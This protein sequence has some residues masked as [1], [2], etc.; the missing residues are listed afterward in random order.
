MGSGPADAEVAPLLR[1]HLARE[2]AA[3]G[4]QAK[5]RFLENARMLADNGESSDIDE[6]ITLFGKKT[7]SETVGGHRCDVYQIGQKTACV[8][9]GAPL[10]MLR[11]TDPRQGLTMVAKKVTLNATVPPAATILPKG[12]KWKQGEADDADFISN[13][14]ELKKQS[15]PTAVAPAAVA[16]YVVNYLASAEA[17]K[18][19]R[20]MGLGGQAEG[21]EET[22]DAGGGQA[23]P[24]N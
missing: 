8:L 23:E 19:L 9:P 10:V 11:W 3:L 13:I 17:G 6:F 24:E 20:E 15:P 14:W 7:G 12:V 16:K 5:A 22:G 2:Y 18:E 4:S 21:S 1:P